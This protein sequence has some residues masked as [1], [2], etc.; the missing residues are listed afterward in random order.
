MIMTV[1]N[2][3]Y[4][5]S[6]LYSFIHNQKY[7]QNQLSLFVCRQFSKE[8]NNTFDNYKPKFLGRKFTI[9]DLM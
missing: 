9:T 2:S 7:R 5:C 1:N 6:V 8:H 4:F 3:Q